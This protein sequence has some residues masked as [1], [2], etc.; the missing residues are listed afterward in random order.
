ML[1]PCL[2]NRQHVTSH[3]KAAPMRQ[4]LTN[5]KEAKLKVRYKKLL[6]IRRDIALINTF[7]SVIIPDSSTDT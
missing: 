5:V 1:L 6:V 7:T 2:L 4:L 3:P